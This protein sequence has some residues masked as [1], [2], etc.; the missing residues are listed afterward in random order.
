MSTLTSGTDGLGICPQPGL[1][2]QTGTRTP[3]I[4][5]AAKPHDALEENSTYC[6]NRTVNFDYLTSR[7]SV[8]INALVVNGVFHVGLSLRQADNRC[9]NAL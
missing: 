4:D 8:L 9:H 5:A 6:D 3:R 2:A 7:S 1:T